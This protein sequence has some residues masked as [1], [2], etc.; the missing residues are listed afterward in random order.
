MF[1]FQSFSKTDGSTVMLRLPGA[2]L[3]MCL[4]LSAPPPHGLACLSVSC[5]TVTEFFRMMKVETIPVRKEKT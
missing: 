5:P 1:F 4:M 2:V 3:F